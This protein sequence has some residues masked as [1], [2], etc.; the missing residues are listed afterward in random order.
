LSQQAPFPVDVERTALAIAYRNP[1]YIADLVL[2]RVPVSSREFKY[3][4]YPVAET[5]AAPDTRVGRKSAPN[6]VTMSGTDATGSVEDFG[7]D[8]PIPQADIDNAP[9]GHDPL[10]R[11]TEQL[12]DYVALGREVRVAGIVFAAGTYATGYKVQLA[13]TSQWSDFA[14]S[15]PIADIFTAIDTPLLRPNTLVFGRGSYSKLV[16]HPKVNKAVNGSGSDTGIVKRQQLAELFEVTN[17]YVGES[18]LNTA[19]KGQAATLSR[20]WGKH[21]AAL[22]INPQ[23]D[24]RNGVTFGYTA[25]FGTRVSGSVFDRN[26]GLRG[27]QMNRVGESVGE[28]VT[29]Q[30]AGYFIQDASA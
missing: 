19:K 29:A 28:L 9:A 8:D 22:H 2:P 10:S 24:T 3:L 20:V 6:Q 17:I 27:G 25:Q 18:R 26:I 15:D 11:S 14:N 13:G 16:Q 1:A 23:A 7:L 4:N 21:M 12:T 5:F 30:L